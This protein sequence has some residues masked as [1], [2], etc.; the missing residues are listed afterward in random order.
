M[1]NKLNTVVQNTPQIYLENHHQKLIKSAEINNTRIERYDE[2]CYL[3]SI[4]LK[5]AK[6]QIN[7]GR[8]YYGHT[9]FLEIF[10]QKHYKRD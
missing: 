8:K 10:L 1:E 2:S 6:S 7:K 4:I 9:A 3:I 5:D